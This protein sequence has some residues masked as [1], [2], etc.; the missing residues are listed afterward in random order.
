[1]TQSLV[2]VA[3]TTSGVLS[4]KTITQ[5]TAG[6]SHTCA[7]DT[8]GAAYCWGANGNG[9]LGI[10]STTRSPVPVAVTT[11]GV[12]SGKKLTQITGGYGH[13]CAL[14]STGAAYCWGANGNGQ[15]GNSSTTQSLVPV[16]VTTSGCCPA[17]P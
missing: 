12:L 1:M 3:V 5:V 4:G 2:P 9:Q 14:D 15:L 8:S 13:T 6:N 17:R 16:A 7:L 11:T 10:N